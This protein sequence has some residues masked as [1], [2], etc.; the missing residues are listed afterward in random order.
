MAFGGAGPLHANALGGVNTSLACDCA[1]RAWYF[2]CLW[3]CDDALAGETSKTII[4]KMS[5]ASANEV[6]TDLKELDQTARQD[7]LQ[8][9]AGSSTELNDADLTSEFQID[10]RYAGQGLVLTVPVTTEELEK[11]DL[12]SLAARFDDLHEQLFTF[13]LDSEKE[14]VNLRSVVEGPAAD[15]SLSDTNTG[16]RKVED[17]IV[18]DHEIYYD[19]ASHAA[20]IYD[21]AKLS[22]GHSVMGPAVITEMDSTTVILPNHQADVDDKANLLIKPSA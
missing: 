2:M 16:D 8:G 21:R 1:A 18:S 17:A 22:P 10:V 4:L 11:G 5:K 14:F 19:G 12:D 20:K 3:R 13:R 6:L 15:V 9:E 7:M